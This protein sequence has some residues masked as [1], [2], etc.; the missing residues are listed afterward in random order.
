MA[1][2]QK[3]DIFFIALYEKN[4]ETMGHSVF[5]DVKK[6]P[7]TKL[8]EPKIDK[9]EVTRKKPTSFETVLQEF[10]TSMESF[11]KFIP[12]TFSMAPFM[13][14][15]VTGRRLTQFAH[16]KGRQRPDLSK[17][18][19][20]VFE[21]NV[22]CFRELAM[23]NDELEASIQGTKILPELGIVGLVST[24]D[25]FLAT[26]L[27]TALSRHEEIFFT[28][29]KQ[30]LFSELVK[31]ASIEEAKESLLEREIEGVIRSSHHEQFAWMER[32][33]NLKL[34]EGLTVWPEFVELCERRNLFTHTGGFVSKQY[35]SACVEHKI[36]CSDIKIGEKLH[37]DPEYYR[38][39]VAIIYEIGVKLCYVLWRK[40]EK[41]EADKADRL[42]SEL[43]YNL[44]Y[45]RT[46]NIA[47]VI[48]RFAVD[49]KGKREE[50][51]LG[52]MTINLA[53]AMRLQK[54]LPEAKKVLATKDWSG[55]SRALKL[56][57]AAV[58]EDIMSVVQL[59]KEVGNK[60]DVK[61]EDYRTWP[62]FRGIR[63]RAEFVQAFK[64]I[65]KENLIN[66][67]GAVQDAEIALRAP[68]KTARTH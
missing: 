25:A 61:A 60:G 31:F 6:I 42:V 66:P 16:S 30:I 1:R 44:I 41:S 67:K 11:R 37:I 49:I 4:G 24:Y 20:R 7:E 19:V 47:E 65:F 45:S 52:M 15:A 58:S 5:T 51:T 63:E 12:M 55:S 3:A 21:L 40:F 17:H 18:D 38:R 23:I 32:S 57:V 9:V 8:A 34:R 36:P 14:Q 22:E 26:L 50:S 35:L 62:I 28:S 53:N 43:C 68:S 54:R 10:I 48:L 46:Y 29:Q 27:K 2:T 39:A 56:G 13:L 33:L 64:S 59:M